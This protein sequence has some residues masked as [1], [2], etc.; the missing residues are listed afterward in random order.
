MGLDS[1][2]SNF[3]FKVDLLKSKR[4]L[5]DIIKNLCNNTIAGTPISKIKFEPTSN[6][7]DGFSDVFMISALERDGIASIMVIN[8][9]FSYKYF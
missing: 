9:I 1:F 6:G 3:T 8:F 5:L 2:K 7:Y 4:K